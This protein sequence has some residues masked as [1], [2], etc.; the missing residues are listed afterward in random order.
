MH[1]YQLSYEIEPL[2]R[3]KGEGRKGLQSLQSLPPPPPKKR[4]LLVFD[5]I[6]SLSFLKSFKQ[7][8]VS[9]TWI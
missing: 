1:D 4:K 3:G 9:Q 6:I 2:L 8:G 7:K 5:Q